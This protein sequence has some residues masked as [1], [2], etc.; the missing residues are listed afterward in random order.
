MGCFNN[1]RLSLWFI[2]ADLGDCGDK[3][4]NGQQHC[5]ALIRALVREPQVIILDE[6]TGKVDAKVWHAVS[7]RHG[8][9]MS[10][11]DDTHLNGR[12]LSVKISSHIFSVYH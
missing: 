1:D 7:K 10:V 8:E 6:T 9:S 5:I 12:T 2:F 11:T 4:S 3:L